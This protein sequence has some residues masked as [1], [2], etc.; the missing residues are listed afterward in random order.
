VVVAAAAVL[1]LVDAAAQPDVRP[2]ADTTRAPAVAA[3]QAGP[4]RAASPSPARPVPR[5]RVTARRHP[6][7][8]LPAKPR[9]PSGQLAAAGTDRPAR[10]GAGRLVRYRV[11]VESSLRVDRAQFARAVH[12]TLTAPRGWQRV[13]R[14]RFAQVS[15]RARADFAVALATPDTTDRLCRPL[16]TRGRTSCWNGSRAVINSRRWIGGAATYGSDLRGYRDYL[17]SHE[18]GHALGHGHRGC[19]RTGEPAPVM[20]QQ[21]KSLQGC[22]ANPW[23]AVGGR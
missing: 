5:A 1:S 4:Q 3:V 20:V 10:P 22:Q 2:D 21:T 15:G 14:V 17:I 7:S 16:L 18:V 8:A 6:A 13:D 19:P 12:R 11:E 9:P 23:P